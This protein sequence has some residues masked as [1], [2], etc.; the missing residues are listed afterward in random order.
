M[1]RI[2][3]VSTTCPFCGGTTSLLHS[4]SALSNTALTT[5]FRGITVKCVHVGCEKSYAVRRG[6]LKIRRESRRSS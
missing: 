1:V 6:D 5:Q 3:D 4:E 2:V